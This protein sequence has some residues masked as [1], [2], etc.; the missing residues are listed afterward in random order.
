MR[1]TFENQNRNV[2]KTTT[3]YKSATPVKEG[4]KGAFALD[5]SGTVMDNTAYGLQGRTAEEVMQSAGQIDV[6]LIRD[7][8]TVMS[9]SMSEEDFAKLQKE[10][11]C[12]T[13]TDIETVVTIVDKI[14][15]EMAKG[16]AHVVGYTDTLGQDVL[17]EIAG[18]TAYAN[19]LGKS[20]Q[21]TPLTEGQ[22]GYMLDNQMDP[23]I[24]SLYKAQFSGADRGSRGSGVYYRDEAKGYLA[25]KATDT[26]LEDLQGQIEQIISGSGMLVTEETLKQAT[27]LIEHTIPVTAENIHKLGTLQSLKLPV[28]REAAERAILAAV[29][30]GKEPGQA[31]LSDATTIYD[32]A[33]TIEEEINLQLE[34][35]KQEGNAGKYRQLQ[36]VRLMMTLEANMKL[37]RSDYSIDTSNTEKLVEA[38][39]ELEQKQAQ[40][41]FPDSDQQIEDYSLY[42]ETLQTKVQI[43]AMPAALVGEI[44]EATLSLSLSEIHEQG[45][46]L[47][48]K[49]RQAGESYETLMTA[50]RRDLGDRI[51]T[52]FRNVDDILRDM[53]IEITEETQRAVRILGYNSMDITEANIESVMEADKDLQ[54]VIS[55]M[56][57]PSVIKMIR[58]GVNPLKVTM[59]E[60]EQYLDANLSY[61]DEAE[62][63]SKYL[64]RLEHS[65]QITEEEKESFIGIYR[66][67]RQV[68]KTEGASIG[69]LLHSGSEV[70]FGN[71]LTSIRSSKA[72]GL[73]VKLDEQFGGL[74]QLAKKE[75]SISDQIEKSYVREQLQRA[76]EAVK[77]PQQDVQTLQEAKI[78]VTVETLLAA[79]QIYA[80]EPD[81]FRRLK[82]RSAKLDVIPQALVHMEVW[83]DDL[84]D[85]EE[86]VEN[87]VE[88]IRQ[89]EDAAR[90]LTFTEDNYLDV[91]AMQ[92]VHK[93][94]G[95][96]AAR[97]TEEEYHIPMLVGGEVATVRLTLKHEEGKQGMVDISTKTN[98]QGVLDATFW[99]D[100]NEVSA[101]M[102]AQTV[103]GEALLKSVADEMASYLQEKGYL[104]PSIGVAKSEKA[105]NLR[106]AKTTID[107]TDK[108]ETKVLYELAKTY[109]KVLKQT[110]A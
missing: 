66:M 99:L 87:Y 90:E 43:Q 20:Q 104:N 79:K 40:Q 89:L 105:A 35:A 70:T 93:Q 33:V 73:N 83:E 5:I 56:T 44:R 25:K 16:G 57:P 65:G 49:Y 10:G 32:K 37:L 110:L 97:A 30:E 103:A 84:T 26:N 95:V 58:D 39:R 4:R 92:A 1:I 22:M 50:P 78:P 11:Y 48:M 62:K 53:K 59:A 13:D 7:Y 18:S 67:L 29:A 71:I 9:N 21:L 85:T 80:G 64:Y 72:K 55:K 3:E 2:D 15:A 107:S 91:K 42:K 100:Q 54:R 63:Y 8:M 76:K 14:K 31:D 52:A 106:N 75:A 96:M 36:E 27:F 77:V 88:N 61:E 6:A 45:K 47:Q 19:A 51:Q 102:V 68:E 38:L 74:E 98:E 108:V 94:L 28:S 17:E 41:L 60:L 46:A 101:F 23:T 109:I 82:D 34:R 69:A 86:T 81:T 12:P 24:D